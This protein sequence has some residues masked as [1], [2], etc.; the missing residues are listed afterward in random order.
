MYPSNYF[1]VSVPK[2]QISRLRFLNQFRNSVWYICFEKNKKIV[3]HYIHRVVLVP[4]SKK[5]YQPPPS[6]N[7]LPPLLN[8]HTK[9]GSAQQPRPAGVG[10]GAGSGR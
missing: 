6:P 1:F 3:L 10:S 4:L 5:I 9:I 2:K 7:N 8:F